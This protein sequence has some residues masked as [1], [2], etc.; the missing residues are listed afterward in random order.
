MQTLAHE[1]ESSMTPAASERLASLS[2]SGLLALEGGTVLG[3]HR[4]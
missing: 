4:F 2:S 1:T 3:G